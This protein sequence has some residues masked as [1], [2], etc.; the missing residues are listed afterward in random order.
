MDAQHNLAPL[1]KRKIPYPQRNLQMED[2]ETSESSALSLTVH[3]S[4]SSYPVKKRKIQE[5]AASSDISSMA[6]KKPPIKKMDERPTSPPPERTSRIPVRNHDHPMTGKELLEMMEGSTSPKKSRTIPDRDLQTKAK[7]YLDFPHLSPE[8]HENRERE[9]Q[10]LLRYCKEN[11]PNALTLKLFDLYPSSGMGRRMLSATVLHEI[12]LQYRSR[13]LPIIFR[14]KSIV[15]SLLEAEKSVPAFELLTTIVSDIAF[16]VFKTENDGWPELLSFIVSCL[17]SDS[18]ERQ[19]SGLLVFHKLPQNVG[20]FFKPYLETIYLAVLSHLSSKRLENRT[21]AFGASVTLLEGLRTPTDHSWINYILNAMRKSLSE[22]EC[23]DYKDVIEEGLKKLLALLKDAQEIYVLQVSSLFELILKITEKDWLRE[24]ARTVTVEFFLVLS[25]QWREKI[26]L[27]LMGLGTDKFGRFILMLVRMISQIEDDIHF[28]NGEG[29]ADG[30]LRYS[31]SYIAGTSCLEQITY[32]L[33]IG[34]MVPVT[35]DLIGQFLAAQEWQ[36]RVSG[37]TCIRIFSPVMTDHLEQLMTMVLDSLQDPHHRVRFAA[38]HAITTLMEDSESELQIQSR[39]RILPALV[40]ARQ[41]T[42]NPDMQLQA[43]RAIREFCQRCTPDDLA[44][45]LNETVVTLVAVLKNENQKLQEM[46]LEALASVASLS[47]DRF[48]TQYVAAMP[49][50]L[51]NVINAHNNV[52]LLAKNANCIGSIAV[53]V[54]KYN[55]KADAREV[56]RAITSAK[57]SLEVADNQTRICILQAL[58]KYCTCLQ[59][60]FANYFEDLMP[61]FLSSARAQSVGQSE[62]KYLLREKTM[63]CILLYTCTR[64][65]KE[66]GK[67]FPWIFKVAEIFVPLL[68][69]PQESEIRKVSASAMPELLHSVKSQGTNVSF[70]KLVIMIIPALVNALGKEREKG[71]RAI[72]FESLDKCI[73]IPGSLFYAGQFTLI[74]HAIKQ[75]LIEH[76]HRKFEFEDPFEEDE[77]PEEEKVIIQIGNCLSTL[78]DKSRDKVLPLLDHILSHVTRLWSDGNT[79]KEKAVAF[80]IFNVVMQKY[81]DDAHKYYSIYLPLLLEAC[82]NENPDMQQEAVCGIGICAEFG[83]ANFRDS[84]EV[85]IGYL[86]S[87][88]TST[89]ALSSANA[90]V[91]GAAV[92][93]LGKIC[94]FQSHC[95]KNAEKSFTHWQLQGIS[96]WVQEWLVSLP[97]TRNVVVLILRSGH[98]KN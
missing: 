65:L 67:F 42:E 61:V 83:A 28:Y 56:I 76:P 9:R 52:T 33:G 63:A 92:S 38:V 14:L 55:F 50:L 82:N 49:R 91:Y 3:K 25:E 80:G 53:A 36:R 30:Q 21:L 18:P 13:R 78:I 37:L 23:K 71:V 85:A 70:Q 16:K 39:N 57:Q 44:P 4:S 90:N 60:D 1:K 59:Q 22:T 62:N 26:I 93:A 40:A 5:L 34:N 79:E 20:D 88:I 66:N 72:M 81:G 27:K 41:D 29:D 2:E 6:A 10:T 11:Y 35:L 86:N 69:F 58:K 43:V 75:V 73:Q 15:V 51:L 48:Q 77:K 46:S 19:R 98:V 97:I 17:D 87:I 45:Y 68:N 12:I 24:E 94:E 84:A 64:H 7:V 96:T 89:N 74:V 8:P 31:G 32:A 47:Q 95:I 54:G